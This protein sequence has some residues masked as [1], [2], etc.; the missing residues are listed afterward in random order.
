MISIP[1]REMSQRDAAPA[2]NSK[3][4]QAGKHTTGHKAERRAQFSTD[5]IDVTMKG[6]D[7]GYGIEQMRDR[8]GVAVHEMIFT[9]DA[10]YE[11]GND[12]PVKRTG[13]DT[14]AINNPEE[15]KQ[16]LRAWLPVCG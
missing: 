12:E 11:G 13:I 14:V 2:I 16:N 4:Q 6:I 3:A 8:L 5:S 15:T 7:K 1:K 10:L 9:G